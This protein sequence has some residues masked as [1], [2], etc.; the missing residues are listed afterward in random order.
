MNCRPQLLEHVGAHLVARGAEGLCVGQFQGGVE[1]A[2]EKN[3]S[4]EARKHEDAET[5]YRGWA[6]HD[7]PDREREG[8]RPAPQRRLRAFCRRHLHRRPPGGALV[9]SVSISTKSLSTGAFTSC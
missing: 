2:P 7:V 6:A 4:D 5:E 8:P 3:A 1:R 9:K